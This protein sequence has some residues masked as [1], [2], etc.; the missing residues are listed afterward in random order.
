MHGCLQEALVPFALE[1]L[2]CRGDESRLV[3]C[4][5]RDPS[6]DDSLPQADYRFKDYSESA[7]CDPYSGT[8]AAV[9]CGASDD[10]SMSHNLGFVIANTSPFASRQR[11]AS[12]RGVHRRRRRRAPGSECASG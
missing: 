4:R 7:S 6:Q 12:S 1:N 9:A 2:G 8:F 11:P 3:D 10:G 5:V